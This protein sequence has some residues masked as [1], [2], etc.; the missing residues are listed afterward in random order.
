VYDEACVCN[1]APS[2]RIVVSRSGEVRPFRSGRAAIS[3]T[4]VRGIARLDASA[5]PRKRSRAARGFFSREPKSAGFSPRR[6]GSIRPTLP[7][8]ANWREGGP[9]ARRPRAATRARASSGRARR[10]CL[11]SSR[12]GTR[13]ATSS[14]ARRTLSPPS[15]PSRSPA[16]A[17]SEKCTSRRGSVA[18]SRRAT[19][20]ARLTAPSPRAL[21]TRRIDV[22]VVEITGIPTKVRRAA[23]TL[24]R[25]REP[26]AATPTPVASPVSVPSGCHVAVGQPRPDPRLNLHV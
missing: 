15:L 6:F 11:R 22:R 9:R 24:V 8:R 21:A 3:R 17:V 20:N 26:R 18:S 1:S 12:G 7:Q 10:T 2:S 5:R 19:A 4:V 13:R 25:R 14:G 23:L 16:R